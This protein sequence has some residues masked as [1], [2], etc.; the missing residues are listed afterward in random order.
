MARL[1]GAGH[2]AEFGRND[3]DDCIGT[4]TASRACPAPR[5][6]LV[7][8]GRALA[9]GA[10]DL[11]VGGTTTVA[12][13]HGGVRSEM[14][15]RILVAVKMKINIE[16]V[17]RADLSEDSAPKAGSGMHHKDAE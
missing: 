12:D 17:V 9:D 16:R 3:L 14:D 13:D 1:T 6:D 8:R 4:A 11:A 7:E 5:S 10:P 15:S 2:R